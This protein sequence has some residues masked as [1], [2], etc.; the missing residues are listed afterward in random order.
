MFDAN[1][2]DDTGA[3]VFKDM[4]DDADDDTGAVDFEGS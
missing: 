3:V 4:N 2:D 1:S